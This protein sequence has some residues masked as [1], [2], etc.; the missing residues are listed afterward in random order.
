LN[1][2]HQFFVYVN[3]LVQNINTTKKHTEAL[4]GYLGGWFGCKGR[5]DITIK[6]E[7]KCITQGIGRKNS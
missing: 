1:G 7:D 5:V 3:L 4:L 2:A 6:M